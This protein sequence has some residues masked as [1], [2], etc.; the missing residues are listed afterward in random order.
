[1]TL[2]SLMAR[3]WPRG[4]RLATQ[5][6]ALCA[7]IVIG[8]A[9]YAVVAFPPLQPWHTQILTEEFSATRDGGL[10]FDGYLKLED[11][12]FAEMRASAARWDTTSEA[13]IYSRFNPASFVSR[14][15][16][17]E[18]YN[19]SFRLRQPNAVGQAL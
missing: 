5:V 19:R 10:D 7:A 4:L 11:R 14:L 1:M 16:D 18:P 12:L 2:S 13:Y 15:A 6:V 8:F 3:I 9:A 17:G